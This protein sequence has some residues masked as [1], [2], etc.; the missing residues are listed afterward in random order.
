MEIEATHGSRPAARILAD[1]TVG[2]SGAV[3]GIEGTGALS[4]RLLEIGFYPGARVEVV[5]VQWP[6]DDP[7]AVRVGGAT[8][9]LRRREAALVRLADPVG[10]P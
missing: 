9:A 3:A 8:F 10:A 6:G 4:R 1:L 7:L 5:A 2:E